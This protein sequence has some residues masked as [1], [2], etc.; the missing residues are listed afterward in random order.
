MGAEKVRSIA[1]QH[2]QWCVHYHRDP[3]KMFGK[4]V[5]KC[6]AGVSYDELSRVGELG[7]TGC[8]LR[9][10]CIRSH[11]EPEGRRGQP[12]FECLKL[13][14]PT[15]EESAEHEREADEAIDRLMACMPLL[16]GI[17]RNHKGQDW[18]GT[19]ECSTCGKSLH[20]RH[21]ACNGHIHGQCETVDCVSFME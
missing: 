7:R 16:D 12:L 2:Q 11:H 18:N 5:E 20:L 6:R 14:W 3:E 9:L 1:E 15:A 19:A 17:R 8:S 10:P 4:G 13:Q 21:A